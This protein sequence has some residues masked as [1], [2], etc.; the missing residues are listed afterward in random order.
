MI[1]WLY[2]SGSGRRR[3]CGHGEPAGRAVLSAG[4]GRRY[5]PLTDWGTVA[6]GTINGTLT[7]DILRNGLEVSLC[8][9]GTVL[10]GRLTAFFVR[11]VLDWTHALD[12]IGRQT[13]LDEIA[14]GVVS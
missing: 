4:C 14:P 12:P 8:L 7:T 13:A 3:R 11:L 10:R 9:S 5:L 6:V 2:V 1:I